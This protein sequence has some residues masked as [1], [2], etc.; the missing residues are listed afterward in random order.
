M[1][2]L[3]WSIVYVY[4]D[5][6]V[7][8]EQAGNRPAVIVSDEVFNQHMDV[9][10][11]LPITSRKAGRTVYPNEVLLSAEV[12]GLESEYIVLAHQIRTISRSRIERG[13]LRL[14]SAELQEACK[15]AVRVH[16]GMY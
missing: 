10:T 4:L 16:L 13:A 5:P 6:A 11:I 9:V 2:P 15:E 12:S 14:E 7:G 3:Q 8:R 1:E